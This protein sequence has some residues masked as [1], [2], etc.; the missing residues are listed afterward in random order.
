MASKIWKTFTFFDASTTRLPVDDFLGQ[1][2][3]TCLCSGMRCIFLGLSNGSIVTLSP[4]YRKSLAWKAHESRPITHAKYLESRQ[5]LVTISEDLREPPEMKVW[6][7]KDSNKKEFSFQLLS[8]LRINVQSIFPMTC[9]STTEDLSDVAAAFA[10]GVI[11]LVRGDLVHDRGTKQR[12]IFESDEPITGI[13]FANENGTCALYVTTI[14]RVMT[15][16]TSIRGHIPPPR[17]L[18]TA[19][20]ALGCLTMDEVSGSVL[21]A[22][23]DALYY[24]GQDGRGPCYAYEGSKSFAG[25][26]GEYVVLLLPPQAPSTGPTNTAANSRHH[27]SAKR[28]NFFEVNTLV[29][30]DT[31]L[32]FIAHIEA[33]TGGVRG[34]V[35]EWGAIHI[36]TSDYKMIRLKERALSDRLNLLYQRDLYPTALKLAQK[37]KITSAEI[38]QINCRYADFLFSKGDY[39]NAMYQY[40]Q[41]IEGTQPSQVIRRF[42]DIQRI[43]NLI[44][45]LEELHRHSE[46]V[47]TEHTTLLLN[48]YA[49]LKDVEK[50]ESFIRS[51]K[52]QRFDLNTVISLC[53]QAGY[54][55]QA[56]FLA[57]QNSEHDIVMDIF[58]EDMQKFQ[59]G[60]NFLVTLQ[61][62]T[63]QR[64]LLKWGRILLDELPFET[65]SL[66]IEFYTGGYVPREEVS[67]EEV[68]APQSSTGGLQGYAAFLQLPYLVN[69]LS[70][71]A[72]PSPE[73]ENRQ[74][75]K[76]I[77]YRVPLP[78]TAFSLFVDHP[79]E[80]V[81]FLESLLST[82]KA[83]D[84]LSEVRSTLFEIYLHHASQDM[85]EAGNIWS[86]KAR[87]MLESAETVLGTSDVLLLSHLCNFQEGTTRVREDQELFFDIFRSHTS[88]HDTA[89]VMTALKKYGQKE[90][91]LYPAALAYIAS[92]PKILEVAGDELVKILETIEKEGLM[93]PLQVV[94]VLSKNGVATVRMIRRYLSGMIERERLEIQQDQGYIDGYRRDTTMRKQEI[95]D[96]EDK[97][98]I[99]QPT[100][101]T[102]CGAALE[103]PVVH[104]LCKHSFH[105]RCL[106]TSIEPPE[107]PTCTAGNSAIRAIRQAQE[108]A[109]DQF[110][111]LKTALEETERDRFATII[112]FF[113]RGVMKDRPV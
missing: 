78:R 102:F 69:P 49:K 24:Y 2:Q 30:L 90:P 18:E 113:G 101:C 82:A 28:D 81:R 19:G 64:N 75:Q 38:N 31:D 85:S 41:A 92:S 35:Y 84:T 47:T 105:Q 111:I 48:C 10:N 1:D 86:A 73:A 112:D 3:I 16:K 15:I 45:Y 108:D 12:T 109:S 83:K 66:F 11:V 96:L 67:T 6:I 9:F 52:G 54:F 72:P 71:A 89:G 39:D 13:Q 65:T 58:M 77:T 60:I 36:L 104:F 87:L 46:Y 110:G 14:E 44:Q 34:I 56:A 26:F 100:R 53:R 7:L 33:F 17:V 50:L 62:D 59:D 20:C 22:R 21:V 61:P 57:R 95:A 51:D 80:F 106:N 107:C 42:L 70:V 98:A 5:I 27:I 8:T 25:S 88:A 43:P 32:Q 99:F 79:F 68:P 91:Q 76:S 29:V 97:P 55:G 93:A 103:L 37:S 40:I 63:M 4:K 23:N 74:T 94:Q